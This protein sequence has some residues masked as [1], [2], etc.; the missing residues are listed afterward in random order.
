LLPAEDRG[1]RSR[2]C[3]KKEQRWGGAS[4]RPWTPHRGCP[5]LAAGPP[6]EQGRTSRNSRAGMRERGG[7]G[8]ERQVWPGV[9]LVG[10]L[11]A[12]AGRDSLACWARGRG[13][14]RGGQTR[15]GSRGWGR[16]HGWPRPRRLA[17]PRW[18][19][20]LVAQGRSLPIAKNGRARSRGGRRW[21]GLTDA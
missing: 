8:R 10:V 19:G 21:R 5:R 18:G 2:A 4:T 3:E 1:K 13:Q 6:R 17:V 7:L 14:G 12:G 15:L 11:A 9:E 20:L 16:G